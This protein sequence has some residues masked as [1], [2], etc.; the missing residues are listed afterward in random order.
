LGWRPTSGDRVDRAADRD[1]LAVRVRGGNG[2]GGRLGRIG[3]IVVTARAE[4]ADLLG[5]PPLRI[6]EVAAQLGTTTRTIRYYEE[7][8]LLRGGARRSGG[9]H[10]SFTEADVQRISEVLRLKELLGLSLEEV[11]GI[12][13]AEEARRLLRERFHRA[14]DRGEQERLAS[15]ALGHLERQLALVRSRRAKLER[16]ERELTATRRELQRFLG[17]P[18]EG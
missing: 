7:I 14:G 15:D 9:A 2:R 18:E 17:A 4:P 3:A 11:R 12:L 13:D 10:R 1:S 8:G 6:G 16:F 5:A